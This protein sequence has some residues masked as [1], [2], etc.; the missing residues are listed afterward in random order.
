VRFLR[1]HSSRWKG[2]AG[3]RWLR[4]DGHVV[5]TIAGKKIMEHRLVY[6]QYHDCCL[7]PYTIIHHKNGIKNDN[8]IENLQP[9]YQWQHLVIVGN[10]ERLRKY[11]PPIPENRKCVKC[12]VSN[13]KPNQR[14]TPSW[15]KVV[16]GGYQCHECYIDE[17]RERPG[18]RERIKGYYR[19]YAS[20]PE[21]KVK[22]RESTRRYRLRPDTQQKIADQRHDRQLEREIAQREDFQNRVACAYKKLEEKK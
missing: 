3:A 2:W 15:T 4:A 18:I 9:L 13:S 16:G 17:Y 12:G 10:S 1:G 6:E 19:V 14:G 20:T 5:V 22:N 8:R 11:S 21:F 7:L